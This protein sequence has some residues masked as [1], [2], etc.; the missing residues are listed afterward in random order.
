MSTS[1]LKEGTSIRRT[2]ATDMN[3]QSSRSHAI[4]SLTLMQKKHM[5]SPLLPSAPSGRS[6]PLSY[7]SSNGP[8]PSAIPSASPRSSG[9]A[10]PI[11]SIGHSSL[12]SR[13]ASPT[14]SRSATP[15]AGGLSSPSQSRLSVRPGGGI[16]LGLGLGG[17][18]SP[19]QGGDVEPRPREDGDWANVTSKFHFVD[20]AGSERVSLHF[21]ASLPSLHIADLALTLNS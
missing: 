21:N 19:A 20:L 13:V 8:R 6:T 16:G 4:F 9:L 14:F 15:S 2:N 18:A 7:L 1:L 17:R 12:S 3:S 10:R 11:S 5:G